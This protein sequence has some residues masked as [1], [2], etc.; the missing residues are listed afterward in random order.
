MIIFSFI[1]GILAIPSFNH[2]VLKLQNF[3][4]KRINTKLSPKQ[5]E[6]II[7]DPLSDWDNR[8]KKRYKNEL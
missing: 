5:L 6:D 8:F 2:L 7:L 1:I 4:N 3:K